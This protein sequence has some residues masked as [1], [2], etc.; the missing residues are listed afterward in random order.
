MDHMLEAGFKV[1][2]DILVYLDVADQDRDLLDPY[3]LKSIEQPQCIIAL[4]PLSVVEYHLKRE[5]SHEVEKEV[6]LK[7]PLR[8]LP[9]IPFHLF[10][11]CGLLLFVL[12]H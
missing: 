12:H 3:K 5:R 1:A 4:L 10:R 2:V 9:Y 7:V 11:P 6:S 8:S